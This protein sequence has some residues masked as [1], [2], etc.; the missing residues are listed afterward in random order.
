[1]C[2]LCKRVGMAM[3]GE[4]SLDVRCMDEVDCAYARRGW[5]DEEA[6]MIDSSGRAP[7]HISAAEWAQMD[8]DYSDILHGVA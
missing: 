4:T 1:M 2:N 7:R 8:D 3:R 6:A 5:D